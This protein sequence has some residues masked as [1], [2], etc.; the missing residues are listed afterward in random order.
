MTIATIYVETESTQQKRTL[1][2]F[3]HIDEADSFRQMMA[4]TFPNIVM[5]HNFLYSVGVYKNGHKPY[6][7]QGE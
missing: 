1:F 2:A 6:H 3:K 5:D 7:Y 4:A